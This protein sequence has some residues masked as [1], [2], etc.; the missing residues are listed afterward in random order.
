MPKPIIDNDKC[1][2]CF[3]CVEICPV[4]VFSK[5][6]KKAKVEKADECIG[7][8]ACEVQCPQSAIKIED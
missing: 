7:C 3:T 1:T 2:G 6:D 4:E 8:R 5:G